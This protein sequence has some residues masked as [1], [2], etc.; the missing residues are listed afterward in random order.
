VNTPFPS[1]VKYLV[2]LNP[3][4][5]S[6]ALGCGIEVNGIKNSTVYPS[7]FILEMVS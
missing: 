4:I 5:L 6:S 2:T 7:S 3:H 1:R